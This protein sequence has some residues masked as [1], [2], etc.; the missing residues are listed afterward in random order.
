MIE[1]RNIAIGQNIEKTVC[2]KLPNGKIYG[3]LGKKGSG[4]S[5]LL[6][7]LSGSLSPRCG[8]VIING[9]DLQKEPVSAKKCIGYLP[10]DFAPYEEMTVMEFLLFVADAKNVS[11]GRTVKQIRELTELTDL[12][13]KLDRLIQK[14][15]AEE[16]AKLGILQACIGN[17]DILLLDDPTRGLTPRAKQNI[18]AFLRHLAKTKTLIVTGSE[19]EQMQE[20]CDDLL[21]L[22]AKKSE[23]SGKFEVEL[24]AELD[25]NDP[26][27]QVIFDSLVALESPETPRKKAS[28]RIGIL[29]EQSGSCETVDENEEEE[30]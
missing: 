1:A 4:K 2:F 17:P 15:T 8:A 16:K 12:D 24:V 11:Y 9:F 19:L 13:T 18:C 7:L 5:T 3:I 26:E 25:G 28:K 10:Q 22:A 14:L 21:I 29:S 30:G 6:R 20:L 23:A 27:V